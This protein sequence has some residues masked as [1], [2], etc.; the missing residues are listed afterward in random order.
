[1]ETQSLA[2]LAKANQTVPV[3]LIFLAMFTLS[4]CATGPGLTDL[5][6]Q[7]GVFNSPYANEQIARGR[8]QTGEAFEG[9]IVCNGN[10]CERV[11]LDGERVPLTQRERRQFRESLIFAEQ[12]R[13]ANEGLLPPTTPPEAGPPPTSPPNDPPP[14]TIPD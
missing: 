12:N 5:D 4:G 8:V 3:V 6:A 2:R 7:R 1:M 11:S 9:N 10:A 13:R 14:Q